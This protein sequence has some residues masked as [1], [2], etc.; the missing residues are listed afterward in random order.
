MLIEKGLP[1][2]SVRTKRGG[3]WRRGGRGLVAGGVEAEGRR[4][5]GGAV[6]RLAAALKSLDDDHA[7]ATARAWTRQHAGLVD[8]CFGR[9]GF[10]WAG[11]HGEQLA[12]VGNVFGSVAVG[13]QPIV[14][15]AM[16]AL[17]QHVDQKAPD[18]LIG[19]HRQGLVAGGPLDALIL[20]LEGNALVAGGDQPA[21][22]D[23]D[24]GGG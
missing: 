6:L 14:P 22:G 2:L 3:P 19:P 18:E 17:R 23:R 24:A 15:D 20:V 10:F 12:R 9:F 21:I 11:R 8:R 1:L 4:C 13:E 16:E 7:G 5:R